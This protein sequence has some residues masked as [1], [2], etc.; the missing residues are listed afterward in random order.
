MSSV[1]SAIDAVFEATEVFFEAEKGGIERVLL[2]KP[3]STSKLNER[4]PLKIK[5]D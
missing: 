3:S 2:Y 5:Q 4:E 1:P